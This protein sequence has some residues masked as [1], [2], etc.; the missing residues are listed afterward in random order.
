M[1][2]ELNKRAFSLP[3]TAHYPNHHVQN[4]LSLTPAEM[5]KLS[6]QG[7]PISSHFDDSKFY[8]GDSKPL[9]G[10][11]FL[12]QRGIDVVDAWNHQKDSRRNLRKAQSTDI[13]NFGENV[14]N[15]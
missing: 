15:N 4:G 5:L 2:N 10:I 3:R 6:E 7:I 1:I 14:G 9:N 12:D 13:K 8:D 11:D